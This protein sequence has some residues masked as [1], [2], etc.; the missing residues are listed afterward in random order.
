MSEHTDADRLAM[1][2]ARVT[3][4]ERLLPMERAGA[5]GY[6][7][8]AAPVRGYYVGFGGIPVPVEH[9]NE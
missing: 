1:L 9:G 4:L 7:L 6:Y 3:E 2:E 8:S 5:R